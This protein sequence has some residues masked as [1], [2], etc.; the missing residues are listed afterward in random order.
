MFFVTTWREKKMETFIYVVFF[1]TSM[2]EEIIDKIQNDSLDLSEAGLKI[3]GALAKFALTEISKI[4]EF[5]D[6]FVLQGG[7]ALHLVYQSPRLTRDLDF[8]TSKSNSFD[9]ITNII[10][11]LQHNLALYNIS[12]YLQ[13][14]EDNFKRIKLKFKYKE[15]DLSL[16]LEL[17][18]VIS[19]VHK[20]TV[21]E[22]GAF[23]VED[24][25]E[26]FV[27]KIVASLDRMKHKNILK[28][29]DIF[30]LYYLSEKYST[31][32]FGGALL[33]K[34]L[35]EYNLS[36]RCSD[37]DN[38]VF[39]LKNTANRGNF[40]RYFKQYLPKEVLESLDIS[41]VL[42]KAEEIFKYA[43]RQYSMYGSKKSR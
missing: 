11:S 23:F 43:K 10:S 37:F 6:C 17:C 38:I 30:D 5:I 2:L 13:K 9:S 31:T 33:K 39:H 12:V 21:T 35:S 3:K 29:T 24:T 26:L 27:D 1:I 28:E 15:Q 4:P 22:Y 19:H 41:A 40:E 36:V 14:N 34:K 16:N 32:G 42:L 20:K 8:T 18:N 7:N 25:S